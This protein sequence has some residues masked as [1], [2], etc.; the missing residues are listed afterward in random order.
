M[1]INLKVNGQIR[2]T[3]AKPDTPLLYVLRNDFLLNGAKFG[4]GLSQCG[5]CTV[6]ID[7]K[8][9]YACTMLALEAV[10]FSAEKAY[11]QAGMSS[12]WFSVIGLAEAQHF[13]ALATFVWLRGQII[14][15]GELAR[16]PLELPSAQLLDKR[17]PRDFTNRAPI[18]LKRRIHLNCTSGEH[19]RLRIFVK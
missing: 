13:T 2:R 17:N 12:D 1:A 3:N 19:Q 5:A 11:Q 9:I 18:R 8:P 7:G 10:Q 6:L 16:R 14:H 15:G 4:C